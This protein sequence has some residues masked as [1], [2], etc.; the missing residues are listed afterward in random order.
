MMKGSM[1]AATALLTGTS[2][3]AVAQPEIAQ[4]EVEAAS[5]IRTITIT[6]C[7]GWQ[8]I[9]TTSGSSYGCSFRGSSI[10]VPEA[11]D[12]NRHIR[13]LENTISDLEQRV[14]ALETEN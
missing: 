11:G 12:V 5:Q 13:D 7:T 10:T 2:F 8:S 14:A 4:S 6:P 9:R 3:L 1:I